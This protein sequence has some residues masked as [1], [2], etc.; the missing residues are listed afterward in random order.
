M[1]CT[2]YMQ[3]Q[4]TLLFI[5]VLPAYPVCMCIV[6]GLYRNF[7]SKGF[8]RCIEKMGSFVNFILLEYITMVSKFHIG[9]W[10]CF[11]SYKTKYLAF[12]CQ[13]PAFFCVF[14]PTELNIVGLPSVATRRLCLFV[15]PRQ[16]DARHNAAG[17]P[18][19]ALQQST[20]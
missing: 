19:I 6:K 12:I 14:E 20:Y 18:D 5:A 1:L 11:I 10:F 9:F 8:R 2:L 7:L 17:E 3:A 15:L 13:V 4:F 16:N